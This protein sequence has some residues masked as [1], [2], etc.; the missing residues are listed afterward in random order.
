ML[1]TARKTVATRLAAVLVT[2][3]ASLAITGLVPSTAFAADRSQIVTVANN[4]LNDSTHNHEIGGYNCNFFSSYFGTGGTGCTNGWRT[5][6]WC[7]DFAKYTW[8]RSGVAY[9]SD[10]NAAAYSF[11][12]YGIKHGTWHG[13]NLTGIQPGDVI[14]WGLNTSTGYAQHVGV[15][16]GNSLTISGN[17]GPNDTQVYEQLTSSLNSVMQVA[18]YT[19][20]V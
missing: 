20:P 15:Y 7:A 10:L 5:E 12:S 13:G 8:S 11:Y 9:T 2:V 4:Q 14:V 6:E 18:G 3:A 16:V 19:S 17:A 1:R